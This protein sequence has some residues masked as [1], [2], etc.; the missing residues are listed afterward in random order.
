MKLIF[1]V[2]AGNMFCGKL[3]V[4][5][6]SGKSQFFGVGFR[7]VSGWEFGTVSKLTEYKSLRLTR[8]I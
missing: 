3:I 8:V 7:Y 1:N 2:F 5:V 6:K 4:N